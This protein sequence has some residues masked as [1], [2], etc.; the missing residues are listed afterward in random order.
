MLVSVLSTVDPMLRDVV[1]LGVSDESDVLAVDLTE[2]GVILRR[3]SDA[4]T[5]AREEV[6]L[7][8]PCLTCSVR[9]AVVPALALMRAEGRERA[10]L[11][12]P[13]A[14][15][16]IAV[17]P[18]LVDLTQPGGPLAGC[19]VTTSVH[20]VSVDAAAGDLLRHTPLAERGL[21]LAEDD[22]RCTGEV[23]MVS[24]GYADVLLALGDDPLGSDLVEHLRPLDT[25]RVDHLDE[26]TGDVLFGSAGGLR[27]DPEAAV[28]R[29]HPASTAAWGG[30]TA[31]G[32]WT[33]DLRSDR[34]FHPGRLAERVT[35]LAADGTLARGC[36][37]LPTRPD[38]V[39]TWEVNGDTASV[40]TAGRWDGEPATHLIVTGTADPDVRDRIRTV[41]ARMLMTDAE[42]A[43]ALA[44][45]GADDGLDEWFPGDE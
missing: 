5:P 31:H 12:L 39:C 21:E 16:P 33:L 29:V 15:E 36:F 41:F 24:L 22:T 34:P 6:P 28:R 23:L 35:E 18:A 43:G 25:L 19:A 17:V 45:V 20:A 4:G 26:L 30:P 3:W 38:T 32:V 7:A 10:V 42:M 37:W 14:L 2:D 11:A 40:G 1:C 27:H 13:V 44:W 8:H 9:E